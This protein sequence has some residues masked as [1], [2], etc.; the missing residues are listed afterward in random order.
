MTEKFIDSVSI[1][2]IA[3][4]VTDELERAYKKFPRQQASAH[5]GYAVLREELDELWDE[6]KNKNC[7]IGR[8]R[9]EAIQV[10]AMAIR[11]IYDICDDRA[12]K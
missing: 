9:M 5:E 11:L 10:A 2:Q 12:Q 3:H 4:E 1:L 8:M 7:S 6:I